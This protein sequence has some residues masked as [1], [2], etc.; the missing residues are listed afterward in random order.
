MTP[1][2]KVAV[3]PWIRDCLAGMAVEI[4]SVVKFGEYGEP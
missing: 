1:K 4:E 2:D 3:T